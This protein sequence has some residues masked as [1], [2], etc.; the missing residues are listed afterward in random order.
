MASRVFEFPS[1]DNSS[2]FYDFRRALVRRHVGCLLVWIC[3][4]V[5]SRLGCDHANSRHK[6]CIRD[7][8]SFSAQCISGCV[9]VP[10]RSWM[11][12]NKGV[13][14]SQ[15]ATFLQ[16]LLIVLQNRSQVLSQIHQ[17]LYA[18]PVCPCLEPLQAALLVFKTAGLF[19]GPGT[20]Q[21]LP[22]LRLLCLLVP[23]P[24]VFPQ[25]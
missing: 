12:P 20:Y 19:C 5:F 1:H 10:W 8:V 25:G 13:I 3:L 22:S 6:Y 16:W 11:K 18:R 9:V 2:V 7:G 21:D 17:G 14:F 23:L 4:T 15:Q 24:S